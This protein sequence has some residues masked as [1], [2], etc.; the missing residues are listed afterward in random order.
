MKNVGAR[1][2]LNYEAKQDFV[3]KDYGFNVGFSAFRLEWAPDNIE[4]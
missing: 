3:T 2:D 1:F 4:I